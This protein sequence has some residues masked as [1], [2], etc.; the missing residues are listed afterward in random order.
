MRKKGKSVS[1]IHYGKKKDFIRTALILI[2][3]LFSFT[4]IPPRKRKQLPVSYSNT[5]TCWQK[6]MKR[7]CI[8]MT[9]FTI[10]DS[11]YFCS[12]LCGTDEFTC[13]KGWCI[14]KRFVCNGFDN[15]GD[16][17]DEATDSGPRCRKYF[18]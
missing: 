9:C 1:R 10:S 7:I 18:S 4:F 8:I 15:C 2:F 11:S 5:E 17:S 3:S 13:A 14:R 12:G 6:L 16:S